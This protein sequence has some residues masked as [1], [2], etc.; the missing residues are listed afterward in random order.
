MAGRIALVTGASRGIGAACAEQVAALGATTYLIARDFDEVTEAADRVGTATDTACAGIACDVLDREAIAGAVAAVEREHGAI[1]VLVNNVGGSGSAPFHKLAADTWDRTIAINLT[2]VF[3]V[4]RAVIGNM[5]EAGFG[6]I[7]NVASS[8]SLKG[9]AYVAPYVAAKHAV[10]GLTRS[11]ALELA[12]HDV[13]VN[14]VCPG[15]VDTGMTQESIQRIAT[16][17][18]RTPDEARAELEALNP[19]GR[20]VEPD[21]VAAA[22]AWLCHPTQRGVNGI[23]L[24]IT[25]GETMH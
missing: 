17:T 2:S 15:F 18:G 16:A 9:Y 6:R 14:A 20:L 5:R 21:E 4:T 22:V 1:H 11:L 13:T 7:V 10:L 24:G 12:R 25:G 19:Q 3:N 8:A 23:A